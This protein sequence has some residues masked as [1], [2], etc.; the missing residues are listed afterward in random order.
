MILTLMQKI[1]Y[2]IAK[3]GFAKRKTKEV[4]LFLN[5]KRR[6]SYSE[7]FAEK[8]QCKNWKNQVPYKEKYKSSWILSSGLHC[9]RKLCPSN[10]KHNHS[11]FHQLQLCL[12]NATLSEY[13]IHV[14][15]TF[16]KL[17][18]EDQS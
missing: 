17:V 11:F 16:E 9:A 4:T 2:P 7:I 6:L 15:Y 8:S 13:L 5:S 12:W 10:L 14:F 18:E 3:P 1:A